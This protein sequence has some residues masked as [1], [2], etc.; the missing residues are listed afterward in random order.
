[1]ISKIDKERTEYWLQIFKNKGCDIGEY[2]DGFV[3]Y[4]GLGHRLFVFAEKY[5]EEKLREIMDQKINPKLMVEPIKDI[6][7][8]VKLMVEPIKDI[9]DKVSVV[10]VDCEF[11]VVSKME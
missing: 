7:D 6:A 9:A 8:K 11:C 4:M 1:M 3:K 10:I 2:N 5:D